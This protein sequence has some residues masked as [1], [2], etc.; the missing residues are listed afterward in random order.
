[1]ILR[2]LRSRLYSGGAW[3]IS[4][5]ALG[6]I[7]GLFLNV[8]LSRLL[9]PSELGAYFLTV[10][11]II[12]A[13]SIAQ[14][15]TNQTVLRIIPEALAT[16]RQERARRGVE[17]AFQITAFGTLLTAFLLWGG[18]GQWLAK[19]VFRSPPMSATIGLIVFW[20]IARSFQMLGAEIFRGFQDIRLATIFGGLASN[21]FCCGIFVWLWLNKGSSDLEEILLLTVIATFIIAL[22]SVYFVYGKIEKHESHTNGLSYKEIA[23]L[24]LPLFISN[25]TFLVLTQ[26][27]LWIIGIFRSSS[28][29]AIYGA[30][31][32]LITI[33]T[34]PLLI[35][36]A[37]IPPIIAEMYAQGKKQQLEKVLRIAATISGIPA[38]I[39][40]IIF[41]LFG[42]KL[43]GIFFGTFYAKGHIILILLSI[44]QL[45]N[46][47][48]GSCGY[49]LNLTGFHRTAMNIVVITAFF[50][51]AISLILVRSFGGLGVAVA[52][53]TGLSFQNIATIWVAVKKTGI[54]PHI[55][56]SPK[57]IMKFVYHP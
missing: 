47:A 24:T 21:I 5:K 49:L 29:V 51:I 48:S 42:N 16:Q 27:D 32:R 37:I 45:I 53:T 33:V 34:I 22:I 40:L 44:G 28:E 57:V 4:G 15:G 39:S 55:T 19:S 18:L 35:A 7:S 9:S 12:M 14:L 2:D 54:R 38:I 13:S 43:L 56:L 20:I 6:I 36:N 23:S 52:F 11:L 10:N 30:A 26:S 17:I 46:V 3:A 8:I 41:A 50:S 31:V 25:L 1:M